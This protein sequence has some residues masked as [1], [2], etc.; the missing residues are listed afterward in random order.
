MGERRAERKTR[1][2]SAMFAM[3]VSPRIETTSR[4]VEKNWTPSK[5]ATLRFWWSRKWKLPS[6]KFTRLTC[7]T[8]APLDLRTTF[9]E[10]GAAGA[11]ELPILSAS[12]DSGAAGVSFAATGGNGSGGRSVIGRR[13]F[14]DSFLGQTTVGVF[15]AA[16]LITPG[17][18]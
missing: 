7:G 12:L 11:G 18:R 4:I 14:T 16:S 10:G 3:R 6:I 13:H 2:R 1:L 17:R 8:A 9:V 15:G 5:R